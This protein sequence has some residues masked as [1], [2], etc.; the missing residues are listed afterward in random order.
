M[1]GHSL[2]S[3]SFLVSQVSV[4]VLQPHPGV[5]H[6]HA[7]T[8]P[9]QSGHISEHS[10]QSVCFPGSQ[11]SVVVLQPH[12]GT[13]H[14]HGLRITAQPAPEHISMSGHSLQSVSFPAKHC[15]AV[16]LHPQ[17]SIAAQSHGRW[18]CPQPA[19]LDNVAVLTDTGLTAAVL[20]AALGT[21]AVLSITVPY[22]VAYAT[23]IVASIESGANQE[24]LYEPTLLSEV[25]FLL[26][27]PD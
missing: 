25:I 23:V 19:G 22:R 2:Q 27:H 7:L 14:S 11:V 18:A 26:P 9:E 15:M 24:A 12:P 13:I 4:V 8:M 3:V 10:L 1:S 21:V 16:E 17:P 6:S 5:V 20:T